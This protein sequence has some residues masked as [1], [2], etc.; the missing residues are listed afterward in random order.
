MTDSY[1]TRIETNAEKL[2][3]PRGASAVLVNSVPLEVDAANYEDIVHDMDNQFPAITVLVSPSSGTYKD[4]WI[5]GGAVITVVYLD[6]NTLRL[7]NEGE[8]ELGVGR[9]RVLIVKQ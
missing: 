8:D 2:L 1:P 6:A 5:N 9:V 7:Y 4:Q 3:I